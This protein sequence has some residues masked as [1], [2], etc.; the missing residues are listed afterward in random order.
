MNAYLPELANVLGGTFQL[1]K[2]ERSKSTQMLFQY[3]VAF[4][5]EIKAG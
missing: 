3:E 2:M 5:Y 4:R 1:Q